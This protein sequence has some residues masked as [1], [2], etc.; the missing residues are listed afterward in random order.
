MRDLEMRG[1]GELLGNRQHGYIAAVGFQLYTRLLSQSVRDIRKAANLPVDDERSPMFKDLRPLANVEL[2]LDIGIPLDYIPDQ[3]A[4]LRF[5]RRIADLQ[6]EEEIDSLLEELPDR[7][8]PLP[9]ELVNLLYQLRVKLRA[10][11]CGVV[12]ITIEMDQLV[13]RFPALPENKPSRNLPSI[14]PLART[15]KN[16]YWMPVNGMNDDQW[17]Q[18]LLDTLQTIQDMRIIDL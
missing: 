8:G 3:T 15:G 18:G 2:P 12:S 16:A 7:F 10:E 1:A 5:Y 13:L 9:Q 14:A 4:R 17:K 6:S 11:A